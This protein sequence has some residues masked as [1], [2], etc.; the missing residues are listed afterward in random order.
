MPSSFKPETVATINKAIFL[1][2]DGT[3]SSDEFGYISDPSL[4][5]L[6]PFT[7]EALRLLQ[8]LGYLL[9][10]VT[11]QSGIARAYFS[12]EQLEA[13]HNRM[14][15][16]LAAEGVSLDRIYFSPYWKDGIVEPYNVNH[17]DRKPGL[18]LFKQAKRE[19]RFDTSLSWML[20]DRYTDVA[21]GKKAGLKTVLLLSGNGREELAGDFSSREYKP[22]FVAEDLLTAAKLIELCQT[23]K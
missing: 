16:M 22:D 17:E 10:I 11:N 15:E 8:R 12:L 14:K 21:F 6:Y 1:D 9:F 13:V 18:G 23:R 4:Y 5:K 3:I 19:F 20:G 2:R 7:G